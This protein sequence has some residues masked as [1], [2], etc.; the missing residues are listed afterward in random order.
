MG[1]EHGFLQGGGANA[2]AVAQHHDYGGAEHQEQGQPGAGLA[3]QGVES[4][5]QVRKR[6]G[7]R[8][9]VGHSESFI[10]IG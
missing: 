5:D 7:K 8:W 9:L 10:V 4:I 6:E 2:E 1:V 3:E